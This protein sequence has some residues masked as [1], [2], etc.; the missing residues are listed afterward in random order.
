VAAS[1]RSER[2]LWINL[3]YVWGISASLMRGGIRQQSRW[4]DAL[5]AEYF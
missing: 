1:A 3:F 4:N 2:A 5:G